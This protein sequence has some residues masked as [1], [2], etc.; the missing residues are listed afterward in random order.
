MLDLLVRSRLLV[1]RK[2]KGTLSR[3]PHIY[4]LRVLGFLLQNTLGAIRPYQGCI[5]APFRVERGLP[6]VLIGTIARPFKELLCKI[7]TYGLSR[8]IKARSLSQY[9]AR[10]RI[11]Y[12]EAIPPIWISEAESANR[13]CSDS[14]GMGRHFQVALSWLNLQLTS[15]LFSNHQEKKQSST[16]F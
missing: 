16:F 7:V 14:L 5:E 13:E 6:Q 9:T 8:A 4:I 1:G 3:A 11:L 2:G 10:W 15:S 12:P